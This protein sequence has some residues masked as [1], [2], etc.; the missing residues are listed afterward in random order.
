MEKIKRD[1]EAKCLSL[2]DI[3]KVYRCVANG[4]VLENSLNDDC[5]PYLSNI[6]YFDFEQGRVR[7]SFSKFDITDQS[8]K[9]FF[10]FVYDYDPETDAGKYYDEVIAPYLESFAVDY[11]HLANFRHCEDLHPMKGRLVTESGMETVYIAHEG[12]DRLARQIMICDYNVSETPYGIDRLTKT[13]FAAEKTKTLPRCGRVSVH[14]FS[15]SGFTSDVEKKAQELGVVLYNDMWYRE[16]H[17]SNEG[18]IR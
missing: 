18:E 9:F 17:V 14:V 10:R 2:D 1:H 13:L 15:V 16:K 4:I 3:C 6:R 7:N 12:F 5:F 11:W 8:M